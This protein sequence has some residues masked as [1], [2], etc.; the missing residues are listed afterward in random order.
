MRIRISFLLAPTERISATRLESTVCRPTSMLIA[1]GK[2]AMTTISIT[3]GARSKPNHRMNSG[4]SATFG[5][6]WNSTTSGYSARPNVANRAMTS[7]TAAPIT[8]DSRNPNRTSRAV[9]YAAK[10]KSR[11]C[12]MSTWRIAVGGDR[13]GCCAGHRAIRHVRPCAVSAGRAVPDGAEGRAR[14]AVHPLVRLRPRTQGDADRRHR[15]LSGRDQHAG[16]AADG[17]SQPGGA[18]ALGGCQQERDPDAHPGSQFAALPDGGVE[19]RRHT[20]RDRRDR[21][22]VRRCTGGAGLHDPV[23]VHADADVAGVRGAGRG[24]GARFAVLLHH[25]M[26]G[27]ALRQLAAGRELTHV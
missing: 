22:R 17:R 23:R 26:A 11:W 16:R 6:V 1:T 12:A 19:G 10:P 14:A 2:N 9:T 5:T 7:A 27:K 20:R 8:A 3:L 13:R 21:R 15:V 25:R 24:V 4:A 18:D